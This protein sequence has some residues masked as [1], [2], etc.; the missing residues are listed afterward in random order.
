MHPELVRAPGAGH[1]GKPCSPHP[2]PDYPVRSQSRIGPFIR[3]I[4]RFSWKKP[5]RRPLALIQPDF[6]PRSGDAMAAFSPLAQRQIDQ[7]AGRLWGL[8]Y[9]R[10]IDFA[11]FMIEELP[12]EAFLSAPRQGRQQHT[13][14]PLVQTV[15]LKRL[16]HILLIT[17]P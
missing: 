11:D 14:C 12:V 3:T 8:G 5:A 2:F 7:R 10:C 16:S 15:N 6:L 13:R 1:Q 17:K 4:R 9:D